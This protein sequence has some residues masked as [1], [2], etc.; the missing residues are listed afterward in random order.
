M[1]S[2]S[3]RS[4]RAGLSVVVGCA[5]LALA[6]EA[7][8]GA[9]GATANGSGA[10]LQTALRA[11]VSASG[12]PPGAIAVIQHG[13]S[14]TVY[15]AGVKMIGAPS[16]PEASDQVRIA[17]VSKAFSG[18]EALALV[19]QGQLALSSTVGQLL[20]GLP[21]AWATVTLAQLLQHT[22]G[23]PDFTSNPTFQQAVAS[24][25]TTA[26]RPEQLLSYVADEPLQFAPGSRY[27]YSNSDNVIVGLMVQAATHL[28]YET[29]L[30]Q[31]V[32]GP[33]GLQ[34][35][36][37]PSTA[38]MPEPFVH[39]YVADPPSAPEDVSQLVAAGW[40]WASGGVV[41]TPADLNRFVRGY[42]QGKTTNS[43]TRSR[44]FRFIRGSSGPP[45]P[46]VNSAGLAI[47]RY[48]T[49]C[50]TV[51]GHT[52]NTLGYTVFIAAS[53]DGTR[54]LSVTVSAQISPTIDQQRYAQLRHVFQTA[55][56]AAMS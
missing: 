29:V 55:V 48:Q 6:I 3:C 9:G 17:S 35:T 21:P 46:G 28:P 39:G 10:A 38:T 7:P 43:A 4:R 15:T 24:A 41:S 5:I 30:T 51:F 13:S 25:P 53:A 54:S 50:G 56:C 40:S 16:A 37:L 18:A 8:G 47:F 23:V 19:A 52:G 33:L 44:Q 14:S 34:Q 42:V 31:Q 45:G 1:R 12:G 22:S 32:Y 49:R 36:S 20:P 26:P 2:K 27:Q 11:L